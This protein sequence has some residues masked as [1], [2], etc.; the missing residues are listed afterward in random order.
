MPF[1]GSHQNAN[2]ASEFIV[3]AVQ[4]FAATTLLAEERENLHRSGERVVRPLRQK[5]IRA[6]HF[7]VHRTEQHL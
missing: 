7:V 4:D 2:T 6:F 5:I 1:N 3:I